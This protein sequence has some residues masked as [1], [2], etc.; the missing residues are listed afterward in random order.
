MI[1]PRFLLTT[2]MTLGALATSRAEVPTSHS[3]L[4]CGSATYIRDA[5][6]KI[7]WQY[8]HSSRDGWVLPNGNVLLALSPSKKY[9]GG[10]VVEVTRDNK[11]VFEFKGTQSR[12]HA[13]HAIKRGCKLF[14]KRHLR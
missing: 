12:K 8:P 6:G 1:T 2:L 11:V 3:F 14:E 9:P 5:E 13:L 7:S 4:A 10:A